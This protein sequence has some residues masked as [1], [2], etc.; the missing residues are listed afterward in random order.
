MTTEPWP[1]GR[2]SL[3]DHVVLSPSLV[4]NSDT[5]RPNSARLGKYFH[6]T[7]GQRGA[8]S[9]FYLLV[10]IKK[11]KTGR[12]LWFLERGIDQMAPARLISTKWS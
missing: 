12:D 9:V 3:N 10:L 8:F 2:R 1:A 6:T 5:L 11:G 4:D 7:G